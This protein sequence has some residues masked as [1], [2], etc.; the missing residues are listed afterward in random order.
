M[1]V[2]FKKRAKFSLD[3]IVTKVTS[4]G[5]I[6]TIKVGVLSDKYIKVIF[7]IKL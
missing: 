3:H 2:R 6:G 4:E 7:S 5:N 1:I